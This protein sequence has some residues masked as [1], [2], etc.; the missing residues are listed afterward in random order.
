MSDDPILT[1]AMLQIS[2]KPDDFD[3]VAAAVEKAMREA[4]LRDRRRIVA[5]INR[6]KWGH[7]DSPTHEIRIMAKTLVGGTQ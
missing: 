6:C 5:G 2:K 7:G 1:R 3:T 4:V